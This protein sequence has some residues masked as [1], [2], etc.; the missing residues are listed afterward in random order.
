MDRRKASK[1]IRPRT[2]EPGNPE[3]AVT[4]TRVI[5]GCYVTKSQAWFN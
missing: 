1:N 2:S 4:K 5:D 3:E